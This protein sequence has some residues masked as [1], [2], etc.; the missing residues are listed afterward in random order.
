MKLSELTVSGVV[1]LIF[2]TMTAFAVVILIAAYALY[3]T[4]PSAEAF[5]LVYT[6]VTITV[7]FTTLEYGKRTE[8][9]HS[10]EMLSEANEKVLRAQQELATLKTLSANTHTTK[11]GLLQADEIEQQ[12]DKAIRVLSKGTVIKIYGIPFELKEDAKVSGSSENWEALVR[13]MRNRD[14]DTGG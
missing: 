6:L 14:V 8:K 4:K 1:M 11:L 13:N 10:K 9:Q 3:G 12:A 2:S 7:G 5:G